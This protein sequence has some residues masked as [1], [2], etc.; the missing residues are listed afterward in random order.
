M[1]ISL[2]EKIAKYIGVKYKMVDNKVY[3]MQ[4]V[5]S[6]LGQLHDVFFDPFGKHLEGVEQKICECE[7]IWRIETEYLNDKNIH[8]VYINRDGACAFKSRKAQPSAQL[9][10]IDALEDLLIQRNIK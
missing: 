4:Q 1:D 5:H 7:D 3:L 10:R 2:E 6:T 8:T 9:S